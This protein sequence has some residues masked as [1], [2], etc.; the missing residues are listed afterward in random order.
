MTQK[1]IIQQTIFWK[2][3]SIKEISKETW[4]LEPNVRRILW[5]WTKKWEFKRIW[6]GIYSIETKDWVKWIF[7]MWD[8]LEEIKKVN[9]KFD[10]VFLDIPYDTPAIKWW[11]RWVKYS[12]ISHKQF[13]EFLLDL[14]K[15]L[16]DQNTPIYYMFSNAPSWKIAMEKYNKCFENNWFKKIDW[17]SWTKLFKN[18]NLATNML[19]R[20]MPPEWIN[21]YSLSWEVHEYWL[22]QLDFRL[23]KTSVASQKP[24]DLLKQLIEQSSKEFDNLLDPFAWSWIFW[25]VALE[26][27]RNV[28]L[29]EL[30]WKRFYNEILNF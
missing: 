5:T 10:M 17:W 14:K 28:T 25:K 19:W 26:L 15:V 22:R 20:V 3:L 24:K 18:W 6:K 27:K 9:Q 8:A 23:E 1:E 21:L 30:S 2:E 12:L 4:I 16:K 13:N 7:K 11:N 29:F